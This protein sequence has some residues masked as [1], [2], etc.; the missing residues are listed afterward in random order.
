MKLQQK[1]QAI[2]LRKRG[3]SMNEISEMVGVAKSTVS[4]WVR[5]VSVS[6]QGRKL[7]EL[8]MSNG[9]K[10]GII[11]RK[12]QTEEKL[13]FAQKQA[14]EII[15]VLPQSQ[16]IYKLYCALLYWCEGSKS[17]QDSYFAFTNSD[18]ALIKAFMFLLRESF[19]LDEKKFRVCVHLHEYHNE[20]KELLFWSKNTN[21]PLSQ[22][23]SSYK[24]PNTGLS[25]KKEYHG[26]A[27]VRYNDVNLAREIQALAREFIKSKGL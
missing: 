4:L 21:I 20:H 3:M 11:A 5:D 2:S 8:K 6:K 1:Q 13:L 10:S 19:V 16:D 7:L 23:I 17:N 15:E 27:Q 24:K 18:P 26:C 12:K 9:Q 14:L 25:Y 22:F